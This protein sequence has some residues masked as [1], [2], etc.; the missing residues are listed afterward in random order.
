MEQLKENISAYQV[1]RPLA[2]EIEEDIE[3][4]FKKYRDP[5]I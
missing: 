5:T 3:A 2:R 1:P 4:V